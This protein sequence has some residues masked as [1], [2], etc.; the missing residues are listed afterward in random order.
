MLLVTSVSEA[1][2]SEQAERLGP[3]VEPITRTCTPRRDV[4]E[5][6]LAD[7]HFAAQLDQVVRNPD[8]YPVYGDPTEFFQLPYPTQGLKVL[9][10]RTFGRLTG[11]KIEGAQ[12][13]VIR[14]ETSFGGGKTHSLI[15]VYHLARGARPLNIGEFV[16]PDLLPPRSQVAAIVADTLDPVNGL[17]TNGFRT[18]T[19]WGELGAQLRPEAYEV[20]RRSDEERTA[21]G[22]ETLAAAVGNEPT[23]I[24]IDEI[25]QHLRQLAS[26]GNSEVRR[27]ADAVPVFLKNL[28]ELAAG[29]PNVVSILTL[30][31]RQDAFGKETDELTEL[32]DEFGGEH[33]FKEA[34]SVVSRFTTGSSIVKPAADEEIA[35]IL[36]RRLFQR[37]DP[38]A[39]TTCAAEYRAYYEQL[40]GRGEQLTGG[41]DQPGT[42]ATLL[43]S[44]Y[45][46]HPELVRVLDKRLSTI[47]NFQRARGALK[48]L[49]EVVH[50]IWTGEGSA[51]VINVAD[52]DYDSDPVLAHLTIGLGRPDF[53]NVA[54]A[55]F[56]GSDSHSAQVDDQRFAGRAPFATRASRTVFTHSLEMITTAGAGRADAV[57]GT[58]R[59]GD[60]PEVISEALGALDQVAWFLDYTGNRWRFSTE[61]NANNIVAEAAQNVPNTKVNAELEDRIR[62]AF[63]TDGLVE[64]IYFP[65]GPAGVRDEPKLRLVVMHHDDLTVVASSATPPPSKITE[66]LDRYGASEGIR[67]FR[68]AVAF[69]VA[70][71][72]SVDGMKERIR[73]DLAAQAV[74]NDGTR[75]AEFAPEVQRKLRSIA[76]TA[77]LNARIS[78]TRCYRHF[79]FPSSEKANGYLRHEELPPRAQ[80]EVEKAQTKVLLSNLTEFGKVR[81]QMPSTDYLMQKAW[82]KDADE[83]TTQ[84]V[85]SAFWADPGAQ[86]ILDATM[87]RDAILE[88]VKNTTWVYYDS[89]AQRAWTSIDAAPSPQIGSDFIL[90]TPKRAQEL[91]VVGRQ[92]VYDD[93]AVA[94]ASDAMIGG[95]ELRTKLETIVGKEPPKGEVLEVLARAAEGADQ[96]RLVVVVGKP[97]PG[98]KALPPSEVKRVGLDTITVLSPA[99]AERLSIG[100]PIGPKGPRPVDATG[101]AGVAFQSLID[102]E[103]DTRGITGFSLIAITASADPGEGVRDISL[104]AKAIGM[105]PKFEVEAALELELD[106][107]GLR[108]GGAITLGGPAASYQKVE[109]AVYSLAKKAATVAGMLRLD[110]RF[111]DP[112]APDGPEVAQLRRP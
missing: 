48:L 34:E 58:A 35:E 83:V 59:V 53:E 32:L 41:A 26:S 103:K 19:L 28:F 7:N 77:K 33:A 30:A 101:A 91:G 5:G 110:I 45:P 13:G 39:A 1:R 99:E 61:P 64:A 12:H 74:V 4:L 11:A 51:E 9:L 54:R 88:G 31:T 52:I 78:L 16:D 46:F 66:L 2:H 84:Q 8:G 85:S 68:N 100:L 109:D 47:P 106:F 40:I 6:G 29:Q 42:Y 22:K 70:D 105:L 104:L 63:P 69:L 111:A 81:T 38:S 75:M 20:L 80:G 57:L 21:P 95:T 102:K 62:S 76:D 73:S 37:V 108:E 50:G 10:A 97:E 96:A 44:S 93:I 89:S 17:E 56:V 98:S 60:D 94:L 72:D 67:K 24:I 71:A 15:A 90:Y 25:A 86:M 18:H 107:D 23:I 112:A 55:D 27:M 82:P 43:E 36:K 14:S 3:A 79:Y 65:S 92:V 87:L 49:A